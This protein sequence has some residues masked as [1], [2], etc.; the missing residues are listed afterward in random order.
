MAELRYHITGLLEEERERRA[1]IE[2]A[3]LHRIDELEAQVHWYRLKK[4]KE[5][6]WMQSNISM[7]HRIAVW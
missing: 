2:H 1:C 4:Y 5:E 6:P 3:S 7:E